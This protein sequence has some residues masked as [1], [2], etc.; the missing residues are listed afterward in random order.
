MKKIRLDKNAYLQRGYP[1]HITI[2]SRRNEEI[3]LKE[4]YTT[5]CMDL[6]ESLCKEYALRPL[7]YCFMP[8]HIHVIVV[9]EGNRSIIAFVQAFKSRATIESYKHGFQGKIFQ[10]RFYDR[11]IRS[12]Q[13]LEN[14]IKYVLENPVR[15][16]I[17]ED[18]PDYPYSK[19]FY[20]IKGE[21]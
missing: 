10:P 6:L 3:F 13:N 4:K 2:C 11:F 21:L 20:D 15:S 17:V 16:G 19:C 7:A 12:D 5:C 8:D 18:Y 9:V 14:E 1:C